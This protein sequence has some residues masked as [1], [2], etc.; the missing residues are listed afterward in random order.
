MDPACVDILNIGRAAAEPNYLQLLLKILERH[1][2]LNDASEA[3]S[4]YRELR[5]LMEG[6]EALMDLDSRLPSNGNKE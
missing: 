2:E 3:A 6:R 1:M 5:R 4:A